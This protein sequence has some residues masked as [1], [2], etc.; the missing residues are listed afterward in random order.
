MPFEDGGRGHDPRKA[1]GL[2]KPDR[3]GNGFPLELPQ[4]TSFAY[5]LTLAQ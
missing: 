5:F 2:W 4:R 1:D 3:Q